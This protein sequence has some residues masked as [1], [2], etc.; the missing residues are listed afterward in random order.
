MAT[1]SSKLVGMLCPAMWP[2]E[3]ITPGDE[4]TIQCQGA[5]SSGTMISGASAKTTLAM[6]AVVAPDSPF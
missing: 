2:A 4:V 5:V 3:G 1:P 6:M